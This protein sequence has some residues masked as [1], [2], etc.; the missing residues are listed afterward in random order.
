LVNWLATWG[1][2]I[3]LE[4][5]PKAAV[6]ILIREQRCTDVVWIALVKEKGKEV[7]F[8]QSGIAQNKSLCRLK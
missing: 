6:H 5:I 8:E 2:L 4:G 1:T 7:T 3:R